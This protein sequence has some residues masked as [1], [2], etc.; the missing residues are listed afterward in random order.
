ML[1]ADLGDLPEDL[2]DWI[3]I[4]ADTLDYSFKIG[5]YPVTNAQFHRFVAAGGYDRDKGWFSEEAQREILEWERGEWPSGPRYLNSSRLMYS[6]L[7]VTCVSW[8]EAVAYTAWLTEELRK[9]S[10]IGE[11]EALRLATVA[12]WQRACGGA[13][14][15]TYSWDSEF[16]A[17]KANTKDGGLKGLS[18]VHMYLAGATP[19]GILDLTGNVWEWT[20]D[21]SSKGIY[22]LVGGAYYN[23]ADGVGSSARNRIGAH[24]RDD[25]VGF[26]V[27]VVPISR[28]DSDS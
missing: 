10:V 19:E 15:R 3:E 27:V 8:Y 22:K 11:V 23:D 9:N 17:R 13:E 2:D 7:P 12:E 16:D 1:A 6:T 21:E 24:L 20:A 26:R 14:N 28:A 4:P 18:P 5:K 25:D